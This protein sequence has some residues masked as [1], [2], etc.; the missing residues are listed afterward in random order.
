MI[1]ELFIWFMYI[2]TFVLG[3]I[4]GTFVIK[5]Y[6]RNPIKQFKKSGGVELLISNKEEWNEWRKLNPSWYPNLSN[7]K[8]ENIDLSSVNMSGVNFTKATLI[9]VN[10]DKVILANTIFKDAE[11]I[12]VSLK[13]AELDR[14]VFQGATIIDVIFDDSTVLTQVDFNSAKFLTKKSREELSSS[15][16]NNVKKD[17]N[18][19]KQN[20]NELTNTNPREFENF[21]VELLKEN[22]FGIKN[23]MR[24]FDK[25]YDFEAF[26]RN[27]DAV[28][29]YCISVKCYNRTNKVHLPP[30]SG[31][32][33]IRLAIGFDKAMIV[34]N[35]YFSKTV[36]EYASENPSIELIDMWKIKEWLVKN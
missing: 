5:K 30:I 15:K 16:N 3:A 9:N 17:Y 33:A 10:F 1:N 8:L 34:T 18:Y 11:L 28:T 12:N 36:E 27:Q 13:G 25:G 26:K 14:T 24:N 7:V 2:I 31:L 35:T 4:A 29:S 19:Y 22:G 6:A 21:V 20:P 23:H 32:N